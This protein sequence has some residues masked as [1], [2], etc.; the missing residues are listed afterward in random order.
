MKKLLLIG[1]GFILL[2]VGCDI[3]EIEGCCL[4]ACPVGQQLNCNG[5]SCECINGGTSDECGV[6]GGDNSC[7]GCADSTAINYNP[8]AFSPCY[9]S[10]CVNDQTGKN[11]CCEY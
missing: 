3:F 7:F 8:I 6:C 9:K 5:C 2:I 1:L 4:M 10:D 11:C